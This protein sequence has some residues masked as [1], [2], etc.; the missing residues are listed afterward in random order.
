[1]SFF[2][3][4]KL[5]DRTIEAYT[6]RIR[7]WLSILPDPSIEFLLLFPR[8][9]LQILIQHLVVREKKEK[10]VICTPT[11]LHQ[12]VSA[13]LAILRYSP[14][15]APELPDRIEYYQTWTHLLNQIDKPI[16]E[17]RMKQLPTVKQL[18][19]GGSSLTFHDLIQKRD[20]GELEMYPHLLLSFYTYLYPVRADYFATEIVRAGEKSSSPN[21][22]R[23]WDDHAELT[24]T[25]FK[26]AKVFKQIHH[27]TLPQELYHILLQSLEDTPRKY[28]FETHGKPFTR[29]GFSEWASKVLSGIFGTELNLTM[30]RHLF[31]STIS[32]ELPVI[33]LKKIG[34]LMGHSFTQQKLYKWNAVEVDSEEELDQ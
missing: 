15:I 29:H 1:M 10:K 26:T 33:E 8:H 25:D 32:M 19:R 12:Y 14:H 17:R 9:A 21:F 23:L 20:S 6:S 18:A 34:D 22:I 5:S 3:S 7:S 28:L 16:K 31:I 11:N 30:I 4:D 13:I 27:P 24:L 2:P